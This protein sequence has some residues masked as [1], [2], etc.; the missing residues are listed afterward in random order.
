[1]IRGMVEVKARDLELEFPNGGAP[2]ILR[3]NFEE[4]TA[5]AHGARSYLGERI[6]GSSSVAAPTA[7]RAAV[8]FLLTNLTGD[9]SVTT[10]REQHEVQTALEVIAEFLREEMDAQVLA[11]HAAS[12]EA[13]S[14]YFDYAHSLC[15]LGRVRTMGSE[16][17]A[18]AELMAGVS[19]TEEEI[20]D[21]AFPD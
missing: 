8:E 19:L 7:T 13:V 11:G 3:C 1:M 18:L 6:G 5:I 4:L 9:L 16:M 20:F 14:A 15:D 21:L 12:E 2:M 10:L 17:H